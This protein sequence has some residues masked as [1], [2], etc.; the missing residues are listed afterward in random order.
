M[1]DIRD[2]ELHSIGNILFLVGSVFQELELFCAES[3]SLVT[4]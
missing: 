2:C 1:I 4:L 3:F